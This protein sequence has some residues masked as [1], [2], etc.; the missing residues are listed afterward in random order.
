MVVKKLD[1]LTELCP[2]PLLKAIQE[3]KSMDI[4]DILVIEADHS[5]VCTDVK[6]WAK[7]KEYEVKSI[8][9]GPG[10]WEIY[11]KKTK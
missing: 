2:I 10:E 4:G 11:I 8:E 3:F 9:T 7:E 1:C 5:C 6:K